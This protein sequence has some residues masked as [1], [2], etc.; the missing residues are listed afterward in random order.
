MAYT[1]TSLICFLLMIYMG[2]FY[3]SNFTKRHLPLR[4]TNYF[5]CYFV[6]ATIVNLFD[7][8]TLLTVNRLDTVSVSINNFVHT[9]Y[10]LS[11]NIMMFFLYMY[12][13]CYTKRN[14]VISKTIK[15]LQVLPM[16][17]TSI[18]ILVFPITYIQGKYTNY[19]SG[20]K[21][22]SLYLAIIFYNVILLW[23]SFRFSKDL[24]REK[25][26]AIIA[27][28]PLFVIVSSVS[29]LFP[30]AL[31]V[32]FYVVLSAAGLLLTGE[33]TDKYTDKQT[34]MFNQYAL[35][36]VADEFLALKKHRVAAVFSISEMDH[37]NPTISWKSYIGVMRQLQVFC[38]KEF[39]R[40]IYRIG[41][42]GFVLLET[43]KATAND[44]AQK[45]TDYAKTL[46]HRFEMQYSLLSLSAHENSAE[47]LANVSDICME[48][49]YKAANFDFLT[50]IRNRNSFETIVT[51][52]RNDNV[53][54]YY[55]IADV[56]NLK[57]TND[58]LGHSA[59]DNLLQSVARI[60]KESVKDNGWVFR[61]GGDEFVVLL[62]DVDI[63]TF[64]EEVEINKRAYDK[65]TLFPISFA[66]GY[67]KL[68]DPNG[69]E[70]ADQMM[71]ENK[72]KMK[73]KMGAS[74]F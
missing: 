21:V 46:E 33:N 45:V 25:R 50:G 59:G 64:L 54:A 62:K 58:I 24:E 17:I 6:A 7:F 40:Q 72:R 38:I 52:L 28:I 41:D 66:I 60:F 19:S 2:Y 55:I 44:S 63:P 15:R 11:I 16:L 67:A 10:I 9:M 73:E 47:F 37:M 27:T 26:I 43:S 39:R 65:E 12:V 5:N 51:A 3:F 31:I 68:L 8:F 61:L 36:V 23:Y 13:Q 56:N 18:M 70:T 74:L 49:L 29:L 30:E 4:S 1:K 20:P 42:N 71:Y 32:I 57:Q 48:S 53:D 14:L 35:E 22:Y 34:D 69:I